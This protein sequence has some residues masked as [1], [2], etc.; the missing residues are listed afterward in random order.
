MKHFRKTAMILAG[1]CAALTVGCGTDSVQTTVQAE[2][3]AAAVQLKESAP[4]GGVLSQQTAFSLNLLQQT[5]AL[6]EGQN[7]MVSPRSA[8]LV[9]A[10]AANGARGA[11]LSDMEKALG[12][13]PIAELNQFLSKQQKKQTNKENAAKFTTA[14]TIWFDESHA[15]SEAFLKKNRDFFNAECFCAP[16]NSSTVSDINQWCSDNTDGMIPQ[17]LDSIDPSAAMILINAAVFDGKWAEKYEPS[18]IKENA[19]FHAASGEEK[20]VKLMCSF[21]DQYLEDENAVGFLRDYEGGKYAFAALLPNEGIGAE[22]YIASLAPERLE[23]VLANRT[24]R[25]VCAKIPAFSFCFDADLK[26]ALSAMGMASA[27][28]PDADFSDMT[29]T[30][31]QLYIEEALLKT[32]IDVTEEG[33]RAAAVT[34][35][36]VSFGA[37]VLLETPIYVTL[38]RPFVFMILDK[39]TNLPLFIGTLQTP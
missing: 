27:F 18:D 26:K 9:L 3:P 33:T 23:S 19:V 22:E 4:K 35:A 21:E 37:S 38:D 6:N 36:A 28:S 12:G 17:L 29:E 39:D 15:A 5:L 34:A 8:A 11:T 30:G 32:R 13:T 20:E 16:F 7:V 25:P 2:A 14:N 24:E 1:L 10:M 31:E